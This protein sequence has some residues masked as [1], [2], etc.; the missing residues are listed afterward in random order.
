VA[1]TDDVLRLGV[2][3][4]ERLAALLPTDHPD[5]TAKAIIYLGQHGLWKAA[6]RAWRQLRCDATQQALCRNAALALTEADLNA[7]W[8]GNPDAGN[9][10]PAM[11]SIWNDAVAHSGL[12]NSA[13]GVNRVLAGDWGPKVWSDRGLGWK[14]LAPAWLNVE[15]DADGAVLATSFDGSQ[16]ENQ[17]LCEA[18]VVV[19]PGT[20]LRLRLRARGAAADQPSG[21]EMRVWAGPRQLLARLPLPSGPNW[22]QAE[23]TI[24]VPPA[25]QV[26][27]LRLEYHRPLGQS[28]LRAPVA[29]SAL[30]LTPAGN[31]KSS[32]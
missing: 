1:H 9:Q 22:Q 2:R 5:V 16:S 32:P 19:V 15:S 6:V 8:Y 20:L 29:L 14:L 24:T 23:Q 13:A 28:L 10:A 27:K 7:A 30:T 3:D 17:N 25:V 26:L 11:I 4:P 31:I 21:L 18:L 12:P